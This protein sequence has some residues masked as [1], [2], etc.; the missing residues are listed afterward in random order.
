MTS[1]TAPAQT[2]SAW[3]PSR[4]TLPLLTTIA[5]CILLY[6]AAAFRYEGFL[7]LQVLANIL[8]GNGFL[9]I[10]AIGMTFVI[11][12]GGI[13]LS[14][15][16]AI[17]CTSVFVANAVQNHGWS[18][19]AAMGVAL[20]AG[21]FVGLLQGALIHLF[22]LQP[23]LVTLGGLFF[24]RGLGLIISNE[25][26]YIDHP[27][28]TTL[29]SYELH[30]MNGLDVRLIALIFLVLLVLSI[31][32]AAKLPTGRSVYALGGNEQSA[33]LMG[34]PV[35]RIKVGVYAFSGFCAALAGIASVMDASSGDPLRAVGLELD[36]IAAVVVGGTLL[37]GGVGGP[38]GTV[39]GV[40]IFGLIQEA[41]TREGTLSS[42]WARIVVG[43]LLLAFILLQTLLQP[44]ETHA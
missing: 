14:V 7:S 25:A 39:I 10:A 41:I 26:I 24:Y 6:A 1:I 38:A 9:A 35:G 32:F 37:S 19:Y 27:T 36:A 12:A 28:F 22:E 23:F 16:T 43:V 4:Q 33:L 34:L 8:A 40:V 3:L 2:Y 31:V 13:D 17:G 29:S 11:L 20:A 21:T 30:V 5:V 15:G 44:K 18:P 42:W